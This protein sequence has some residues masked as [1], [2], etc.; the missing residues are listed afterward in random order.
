MRLEVRASKEAVDAELRQRANSCVEGL[1][2]AFDSVALDLKVHGGNGS[3][4]AQ[5]VARHAS[6][7]DS[8]SRRDVGDDW[9]YCE[10]L[11][12]V[13]AGGLAGG[14]ATRPATVR[15]D[16]GAQRQEAELNAEILALM[17]AGVPAK[18]TGPLT[19]GFE[20]AQQAIA[21][22]KAKNKDEKRVKDRRKRAG[23]AL[24][25]RATSCSRAKKKVKKSKQDKKAK[26]EGKG[27]SSRRSPS[28]SAEKRSQ[29]DK[30]GVPIAR[31]QMW[32]CETCRYVNFGSRETRWRCSAPP[33]PEV[34]RPQVLR[35]AE[36]KAA[37]TGDGTQQHI[38]GMRQG[39]QVV[40]IFD[41]LGDATPGAG[42]ID[43]SGIISTEGIGQHE[44]QVKDS[45]GK[46]VE[47]GI[48][49][50]KL[51]AR[52]LVAGANEPGIVKEVSLSSEGLK[53]A[54]MGFGASDAMDG[55]GFPEDALQKTRGRIPGE[56]EVGPAAPAKERPRRATEAAGKKAKKG[57]VKL[58][59]GDEDTESGTQSSI[60]R[61]CAECTTLGVDPAAALEGATGVGDEDK[62]LQ[63]GCEA[64]SGRL[65]E[66][67]RGVGAAHSSEIS[68]MQEAVKTLKDLLSRLEG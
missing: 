28:E 32:R 54:A 44:E 47:I 31:V 50:K 34:K 57:R 64:Q 13:A 56:L 2:L 55:I 33:P 39:S 49:E 48:A 24:S 61:P 51:E 58:H 67:A 15:G 45:N 63:F 35:T 29:S 52:D 5:S 53:H 23:D 36:L 26:N 60:E 9:S 68:D 1:D 40:K 42:S 27:K 3:S 11:P 37:A 4:S 46:D 59:I 12:A 6:Q 38:I 62:Q 20:E 16:A 8:F 43:K 14:E 30:L 22:N 10:E 18:E 66:E 17:R 25:S 19:S 21:A 65:Q 41:F 7:K